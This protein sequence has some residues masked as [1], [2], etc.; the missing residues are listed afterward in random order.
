V[1]FPY[2]NEA[3]LLLQEG[4][5]MD[6]IDAVATKFGMPMGPIALQDL[7][8]LDTSFYAGQVLEHAY[9]DRAVP[10]PILG[11]LV[12]SGQ[13]GQKSGAGFRKHGGKRP[14][15]NP[16][17]TAILEK[18]RVGTPPQDPETIQ[19]RLFLPML[20]EATRVLEEKIVREPADA[21]M[22]LILGIGF[23][24]FRGGILRWCDTEGADKL[25]ER[26]KGFEGL[27][28]RFE[29]T[30]TLKRHAQTGERFYPLPK[31]S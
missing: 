6:T 28:K 18:H 12:K 15:P 24:P 1:L 22:G 4:V 14:E 27:G 31:L 17:F 5:P 16:A 29:P 2:M 11:D 20:L 21:D 30:E 19:Y 8:G 23:P 26:L 9:P 10:V 7:V 3:L 25:L 13:L